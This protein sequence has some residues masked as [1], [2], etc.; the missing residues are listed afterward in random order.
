MNM[1]APH[2]YQSATADDVQVNQPPQHP[3]R[4]RNPLSPHIPGAPPGPYR[5]PKKRRTK[6]ATINIAT[7]NMNGAAAPSSNM[8]YL[9]KWSMIN[10]TIYKNKI[11]ILAIQETHLSQQMAETI[12]TCFGKNL[13]IFFSAPIEAQ[14]ARAGIAFVINKALINPRKITA[15][16]LIPGRAMS[17]KISWLETSET[18]LLNIYAPNNREAHRNFWND[19]D[20]QRARKHLPHPN[21]VLGDFNVTED[22]IDRAPVRADDPGATEALRNIRQRWDTVDTWRIA[23]PNDIAFTY[24]ANNNGQQ[25]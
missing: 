4:L 8:T 25:I 22:P 2:A 20:A 5:R 7:L 18:H 10:K 24:R 21:F 6:K 11:A 15:H 17:L 23:H 16:E 13:D 1:P 12:V 14:Q 19:I 3:A 9:E